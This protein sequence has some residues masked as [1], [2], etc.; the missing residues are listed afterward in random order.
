MSNNKFSVFKGLSLITH[1]GLVMTIP[2]FG[3]VML[4]NFLDKKL[5]TNNVF[6]LIL[7]IIGVVSGFINVYKIVM[8][9]IKKK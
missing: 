6:L 2:I 9:D 1:L 3:G 4:G 7:V 5:H 8:S